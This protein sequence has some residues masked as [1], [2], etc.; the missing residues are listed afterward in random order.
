MILDG[1]LTSMESQALDAPFNLADGHAQHQAVVDRLEAARAHLL[2][3]LSG[4]LV[5]RE[6]EQAVAELFFSLARQSPRMQTVKLFQSASQAIE[7]TSQVVKASGLKTYI[8]EPTFDNIPDTFCRNAAPSGYWRQSLHEATPL[9]YDRSAV[10]CINDQGYAGELVQEIAKLPEDSAVFLVMPNNPTGK[11]LREEDFR[12]ICETCARNKVLLICDFCFRFY[13]E[14]LLTWDQYRIAEASGIDYI[15][16]E[17]TGKTFPIQ[18]TKVGFISTSLR[19]AAACERVRQD[20]LLCIAPLTLATIYDALK[21]AEDWGVEATLVP[22]RNNQLYLRKSFAD[23]NLLIPNSSSRLSVEWILSPEYPSAQILAIG[24]EVGVHFL[25]GG[26]FFWRDPIR[27]NHFFR[28]AL[29]RPS[30][31][32]ARGLDLF[33]ER[34]Q[35]YSR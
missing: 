23:L 25:A 31:Y 7:A 24:R 28:V 22:V 3:S 1:P 32:F 5:S 11:E 4:G 12:A 20:M 14:A 17:D 8:I 26:L 34:F 10:G 9:S 19:L 35:D 6:K 15:F 2:S 18:D 21:A 33:V 29:S 30:A 13:S 16:I 27:G